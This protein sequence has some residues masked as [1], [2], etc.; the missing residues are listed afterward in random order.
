M[1]PRR[2]PGGKAHIL[3]LRVAPSAG[4]GPR[5]EFEGIQV[6]FDNR[7]KLPDWISNPVIWCLVSILVAG[8]IVRPAINPN[9]TELVT[10]LRLVHP[11]GHQLCSEA[12]SWEP[13]TRLRPGQIFILADPRSDLTRSRSP[14]QCRHQGR[15]GLNTIEESEEVLKEGRERDE[16]RE[17]FLN[18]NP[19]SELLQI[20]LSSSH[21][22]DLFSDLVTHPVPIPPPGSDPVRD[23]TSLSSESDSVSQL[24]RDPVISSP[25]RLEFLGDSSITV[26]AHTIE[27]SEA[28]KEVRERDEERETF[29]IPSQIPE[30]LQIPLRSSHGSDLIADLVT[31]SV[32][33]PPPSSDPVRHSISPSSKSDSVSQLRRNP[34]ITL[35][36][37]LDVFLG[38]SSITVLEEKKAEVREVLREERER[39]FLSS[40]YMSAM[41]N[42]ESLT[43]RGAKVMHGVDATLMANHFM[44]DGMTFDRIVFNFPHGGFFRD[45]SR[46]T[47]LR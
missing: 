43:S 39:E 14:R 1:P 27:V 44:F 15:V 29:P 16:E 46:E 22:S 5:Q 4:I 25:K 21:Y 3:V 45:E 12:D 19:I 9:P 8:L 13:S 35:P 6:L 7:V 42:I 30:L 32:P 38:D 41:S 36:K 34:A 11:L 26:G 10:R 31:H 37:W 2:V 23:S 17:T 47:Q 33:N 40:N 18:R 28:L 24:R 20:P